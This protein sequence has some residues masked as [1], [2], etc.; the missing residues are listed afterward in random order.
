MKKKIKNAVSKLTFFL[1][2]VIILI[3]ISAC[4]S[5]TPD[6][7]RKALSQSEATK[8]VSLETDTYTFKKDKQYIYFKQQHGATSVDG[9]LLKAGQRTPP[10]PMILKPGLTGKYH[11]SFYYLLLGSTNQKGLSPLHLHHTRGSEVVK[12]FKLGTTKKFVRQSIPLT[13]EEGDTISIEL[14][15]ADIEVAAMGNPLFIKD[16]Q[17]TPKNLVFIVIADTLRIDRLGVYNPQKR[18]SPRI[19]GFSKDAAVFNQAYSTS[20]WTLPAHMSLFTGLYP[21]GHNVNFSDT[22]IEDDIPILFEYLQEKFVTYC[23]NANGYMSGLFGFSR[24]F[25]YY[26][27]SFR[28]HVERKAALNLFDNTKKLI[29]EE[30]HSNALFVLHTYQIHTPYVPEIALAEEYYN[31]VSPGFRHFKF[32]PIE[33]IKNGKELYKQATAEDKQAIETI[34]D[35]GVYTFDHRFGEFIDF[36]KEKNLYDRS[37]IIFTSDHG[38]EF[39]DHGAWEHGHSL[40]NELIKIPLLVKFPQNQH[41]GAKIDSIVSIADIVPT[42]LEIYD[43]DGK[44]EALHGI[45]LTETIEGSDR[46]DNRLVFSYLAPGSLRKGIPE[47]IAVISSPLKYIKQVKMTDKDKAY[48]LLPPPLLKDEMYNIVDDPFEKTNIRFKNPGK[49]REFK[50]ILEAVTLKRGKK[51]NFKELNEMLRSLGY[52]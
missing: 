6:I 49:V 15:K 4:G 33:F 22:K 25:D 3:S 13:L 12:R 7:T 5:K 37:T 29:L 24:G 20:P 52:L 32:N 2:P 19:D 42:L 38:E 1:V 39:L 36:L 9:A 44:P 35:A 46:T 14:K 41:A 34:Y 47:K 23:F 43:I 31:K 30:K 48:F 28:D 45:P 26:R 27:E 8:E 51:G 18:C 10:N 11:M 16:Q 17:E 40:Y 21:Q 50:K